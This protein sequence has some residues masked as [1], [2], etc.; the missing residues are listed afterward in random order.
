MRFT[1]LRPRKLKRLSKE[2][3]T[4]EAHCNSRRVMTFDHYLCPLRTQ[5]HCRH[6]GWRGRHHGHLGRV[7]LLGLPQRDLSNRVRVH[8]TIHPQKLSDFTLNG[9]CRR[10]M[11]RCE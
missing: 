8:R 2:G 5:P 3:T 11:G 6:S 9:R 7:V 10:L 1:R 4:R